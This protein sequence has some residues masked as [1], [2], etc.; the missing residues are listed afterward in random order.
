MRLEELLGLLLDTD[1]LN[2]F[3]ESLDWRPVLLGLARELLRI[4]ERRHTRQVD[5][6]VARQFRRRLS[7]L[8]LLQLCQLPDKLIAL[9]FVA[10]LASSLSTMIVKI[11]RA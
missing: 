3:L 8:L 2:G 7:L 5:H 10:H 4:L 9:F 11:G 6:Y 1:S